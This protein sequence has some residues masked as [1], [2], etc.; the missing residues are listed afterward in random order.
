MNERIEKF[1]ED[2]TEIYDNPNTGI[3]RAVVDYKI[4][5][6]WIVRECLHIID[7]EGAGEG[8]CIRAMVRIQEHFGVKR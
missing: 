3:S 4:F 5:A 7:D 8:G 2:A 6:E 1:L